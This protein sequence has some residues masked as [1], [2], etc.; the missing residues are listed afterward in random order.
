MNTIPHLHLYK[1]TYFKQIRIKV[2]Q[3]VRRYVA[4]D[5]KPFVPDRGVT[6]KTNIKI[7]FL[8]F[9]SFIL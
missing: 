9:L 5:R 3:K 8:S 1:S 6:D 2:K 7:C 4:R